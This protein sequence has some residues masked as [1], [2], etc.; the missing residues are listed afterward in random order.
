VENIAEKRTPS[1]C[2]FGDFAH[3]DNF[4]LKYKGIHRSQKKSI[5]SL[6]DILK[7]SLIP[8]M[9]FQKC[10]HQT[11]LPMQVPGSS[12]INEKNLCSFLP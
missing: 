12:I 10:L 9:N 1:D 11:L 4:L 6:F 3:W 2:F 8:N 7:V 5:F